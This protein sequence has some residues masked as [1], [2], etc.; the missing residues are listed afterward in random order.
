MYAHE[1]KGLRMDAI[2]FGFKYWKKYIVAAVVLQFVSF[3]ASI[4]DLLIPFVSELFVDFVIM[5]NDNKASGVFAFLIDGDYGK[6][7]SFELFFNIA[8]VFVGLLVFRLIF[9]YIKNTMFEKYALKFET[10]LRI[11]TFDKLMELD[12]QTVSEYNTGEL[13]TTLHTDTI[14]MKDLFG[15]IIPGMFDSM[16][17]FGACIV[18]LTSINST[19]LIIPVMLAPFFVVALLKFRKKAQINYRAIRTS[20][21]NMNLTVQENIEAVRLVR[22]FTNE[23]R[24]KEK[25]DKSNMN[26]KQSY[27]NQVKLSAGFEVIFSSIKQAAYIGTI[28]LCALLVIKGEMLVGFLVA[29]S[30]YV[31]KIMDHVSQINNLLFQM[32]Q[33]IVA[34]D[35]IMRFMDCKTKIKDGKKTAKDIDK[36]D[37]EFENVTLELG[38]KK[39]L[40]NIN[41]SIPYG[42]K[43]GIVGATGSGKS[44]LLKSIVR[45]NDVNDGQIK[46][47]GTNVKEYK[48]AELREKISYVFQ[49]AF[50]FSNTI[51]SN[52][53]FSNPD[54]D[55]RRVRE[56]AKRAMADDFINELSDGYQTI[57][58][59]KG[60][61]LSGGQKQ[62]VSIARAMLKDAPVFVFDDSTSALDAETE[63]KLLENLRTYYKERTILIAAHKMSSVVDCDEIIYLSNGKIVERGT[64]D[65]LME[66]DG[67][68]AG[69]YKTQMAKQT[70]A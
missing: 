58:G 23:G 51:D 65:E 70:V 10:D 57:V 33:Q 52:I 6:R 66:L 30:G 47:N 37:I 48:T 54:V 40:D 8:M 69:V 7:H 41:L 44:I 14:M 49:D 20:N 15:R 22:S 56:C 42:K 24:E 36:P 63:R 31:M 62:R 2:K 25:F 60:F 27:I 28:A 18:L 1:K 32:Q 3:L 35:K 59:E 9:I 55:E 17:V 12:S 19:L 34:G 39:V 5:D 61:G 45:V 53:A 21:S 26:M 11:V 13:L 38:G 43:V 50:L 67:H 64:F 29:A 68:F 16:F 4:A 46:M